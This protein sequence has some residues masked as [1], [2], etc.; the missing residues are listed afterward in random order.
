[1]RRTAALRAAR[2][3]GGLALG[4]CGSSSADYKNDPRPP[5]P[6]VITGYIDDQRVS[7]SPRSLGAGPI[8]LIV[9]NQTEHRA[10]RDARERRP[11]G[12]GPGPQAGHG[13]DQPARHGDAEGRRHARA[14]T[15]STSAATPSAPRGCGSAPSARARRTT[16]CNRR[17]PAARLTPSA[18]AGTGAC[19][20]A[21]R[22]PPVRRPRRRA[23]AHPDAEPA[24]ALPRRPAQGRRARPAASSGC[25]APTPDSSTP[26]PVFAD[27]TGDGKSDAVVTVENGGAAGAVAAY[28]LTAEGSDSGALRVAFRNQSLYRG[29]VR[30]S[31]PTVTVVR[32]AS[33]PA[34]TTS[35]AR[36]SATERDYA[37]DATAKTFT[38]RA[39]RTV[40]LGQQPHRHGRAADGTARAVQGDAARTSS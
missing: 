35:A 37:W 25:C 32:P 36:A 26:T 10:A 19:G 1:M 11:D 4:G 18:H 13:A 5:S 17:P 22:R 6:I 16:C 30:T 40:T 8:S 29:R 15:R 33:T 21:V 12:L 3:R 39:T 7:V 2:G 34:A 20:A 38:R 23:G 31:G 27:L 14:A 24:G 28:V 9:T